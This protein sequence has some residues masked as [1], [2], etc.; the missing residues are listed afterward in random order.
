M[1]LVLGWRCMPSP[2]PN[3]IRLLK[4]QRNRLAIQNHAARILPSAKGWKRASIS[5]LP[6]QRNR[7]TEA[8]EEMNV[9]F[10]TT[11]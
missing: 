9:I 1:M 11:S 6:I 10:N 2:A 8:S 7:A 3:L 5:P 4:N